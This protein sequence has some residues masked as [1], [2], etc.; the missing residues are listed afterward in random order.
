MLPEAHAD[1]DGVGPH[2]SK[3]FGD[4]RLAGIKRFVHG[5]QSQAGR[6]A[7]KTQMPL[8]MSRQKVGDAGPHE[9]FGATGKMNLHAAE[10]R[11]NGVGNQQA[12]NNHGYPDPY[13][14][15]PTK[16][17]ATN[18][19]ETNNTQDQLPTRS[20]VEIDVGEQHVGR[21]EAQGAVAI[22]RDD[23]V[24]VTLDDF[25][26]NRHSR[27]AVVRA[28]GLSSRDRFSGGDAAECLASAPVGI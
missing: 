5:Q 18:E 7:V 10:P 2:R 9:T 14:H 8:G 22:S 26:A 12:K 19:Q 28:L 15:G 25:L 21:V 6:R 16:D 27:G 1:V 24:A 3:A 11:G 4:N 23:A 20:I 17:C 13:L